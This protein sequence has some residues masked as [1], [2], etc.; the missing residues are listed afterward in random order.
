MILRV[1][2]K[3]DRDAS[4]VIFTGKWSESSLNNGSW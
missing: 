3:N 2:V 4:I 1:G